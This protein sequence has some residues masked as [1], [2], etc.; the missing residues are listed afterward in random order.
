MED[1]VEDVFE[2]QLKVRKAGSVKNWAQE[3]GEAD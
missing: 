3:L 2:P 1:E